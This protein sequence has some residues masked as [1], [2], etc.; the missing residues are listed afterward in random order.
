MEDNMSK[1]KLPVHRFRRGFVEKFV[2]VHPRYQID[3]DGMISILPKEGSKWN[4]PPFE[5]TRCLK[6]LV[7]LGYLTQRAKGCKWMWDVDKIKANEKDLTKIQL[8]SFK[9][10]NIGAS[11]DQANKIRREM[12][13][14][15]A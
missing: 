12:E 7:E 2:S 3:K 13:R 11:I 5:M 15:N 6:T 9:M 8:N 1:T 10:F 4:D 14:S